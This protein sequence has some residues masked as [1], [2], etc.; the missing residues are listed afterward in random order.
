MN[1]EP[2][3]I[4]LNKRVQKI[5]QW[6]LV[7]SLRR[8]SASRAPP[9]C[10]LL[11]KGR[12]MSSIHFLHIIDPQRRQWWRRLRMLNLFPQSGQKGTS[13]SLTQ[14]TT[15]FSIALRRTKQKPN[16]QK[17]KPFKKE[18]WSGRKINKMNVS[19]VLEL[20]RILADSVFVLS[21]AV[22]WQG[23]NSAKCN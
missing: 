5:T 21:N 20:P 13:W 15:D 17:S 18:I 19:K 2:M 8:R 16:K 12:L 11:A 14:G 9:P 1:E 22:S 7:N 4:N 23:D 10:Y 6:W 3:A